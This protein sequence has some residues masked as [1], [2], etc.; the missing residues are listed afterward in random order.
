MKVYRRLLSFARPSRW[1]VIPF[2]I[3][4]ILTVIFSIFQ[5]ALIIPLLNV[6]FNT[7]PESDSLTAPAF[8]LSTSFLRDAFYYQVYRLKA[9][10]PVYA[11]Y[12]ITFI[13]VCAVLLTN[14][15]RYL[16]Q[17]TLI[18]A[19]T[20]LVKRIR[21][22]LFEKINHLHMG[23]FT[24]EHKGDLISRMNSD[25]FEIEGVFA[26]SLEVMFKEPSMVIGYFVTLFAISPQ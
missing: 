21:E 1:F 18:R 11:L 3:F 26:N 8:S 9:M 16:A 23:F 22:A 10:N 20:L 7:S 19:R 25:V 24:K 17:R 13:I 6:L 15:F 2:S 14:L 5:F 12:F 4:T